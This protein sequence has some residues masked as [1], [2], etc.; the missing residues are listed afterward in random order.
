MR[1]GGSVRGIAFIGGEGPSA[2]I[3]GGLARGADLIVA[4][5]SG[6]IAAEAAGVRPDW[7]L[8]DMDSLDDPRRLEKYP[9]ERVLS[10]PAG[11][12]HTDTELALRLLWERGCGETW[13]L[14]GGGGRI[15]HLLAIRALFERDPCPSRWLTAAEDIRCIGAA[16]EGP[17]LLSLGPPALPPGSLVSV[18]PAG[19][20][21]WRVESRGLRWLLGDLSWDRGFFGIS[22]TAPEGR[23]SLRVRAGKFLVVVPLTE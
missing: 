19:G 17:A 16:G 14:G 12:D 13:L 1:A 10:Y 20:G 3:C 18:F 2:S 11:K 9:P 15:D 7:V 4:A 22:N 23:F 5:D 6:L 8:G 21:P